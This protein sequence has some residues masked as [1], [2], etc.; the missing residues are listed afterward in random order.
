MAK[1]RSS[2][3]ESK[4]NPVT[5]MKKMYAETVSKDE[6]INLLSSPAAVPAEDNIVDGSGVFHN[7]MS[8]E[9]W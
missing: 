1:V 9:D 8:F 3:F 2:S 7:D 5:E 6:E 4:Y